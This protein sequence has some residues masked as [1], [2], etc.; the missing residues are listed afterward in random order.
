[1]DLR[2]L[3][4]V[5]LWHS[6]SF[7]ATVGVMGLLNWALPRAT[8]RK[9]NAYGA[10]FINIKRD[11]R[12]LDISC[13]KYHAV[14][15]TTSGDVY[16]WGRQKHQQQQ[17]EQSDQAFHMGISGAQKLRQAKDRKGKQQY[18]Q[19]KA[20]ESSTYFEFSP[21]KLVSALR[22]KRAVKTSAGG[23]YTCVVTDV[24]DLYTGVALQEKVPKA[25][26]KRNV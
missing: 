13:A 10:K 24:G 4:K 21:P 25:N 15:V 9:G 20:Q 18:F 6:I 12:V 2:R 19:A 5:L 11:V 1:M 8:G 3:A 22:G 16:T 7:A 14:A 23:D 26:C 17:Q